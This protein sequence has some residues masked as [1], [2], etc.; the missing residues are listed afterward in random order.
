MEYEESQWSRTGVAQRFAVRVSGPA[1]RALSPPELSEE[2]VALSW[3]VVEVE[4]HEALDEL[5]SYRIRLKRARGFDPEWKRW[6]RDSRAA[7]GQALTL[8]VALPGGGREHRAGP[9]TWTWVQGW[10]PISG[11]LTHITH[12]GWDER[13][14]EYEMELGPWLYAA[15]LRG[16]RRI[17]QDLDVR[18]ILEQLLGAY[19]GPVQW[20]LADRYPRR[21]FQVQYRE[22]DLE[23]FERMVQEWGI[24]YHFE[25]EVG[26]CT[27]VLGDNLSAFPPPKAPAYERLWCLEGSLGGGHEPRWARHPECIEALHWCE[28]LVPGRWEGSD[29]DYQHPW[30]VS[31]VSER[32]ELPTAHG[33]LGGSHW[34]GNAGVDVAQPAAGHLPPRRGQDNLREQAQWL[35]RRRLQALRAPYQRARGHGALRGVQPGTRLYAQGHWNT[36][37]NDYFVVLGTRLR[38]AAPEGWSAPPW[39]WCEAREDGAWELRCE[40]ELQPTRTPVRPELRRPKPPVESFQTA[41]VMGHTPMPGRHPGEPCVDALGR[42]RVRLDWDERQPHDERASCWVRMTAPAAADQAGEIWVPRAGQEVVVSFLEGDCDTPVCVGALYSEAN[43]PPWTLPENAAL[44]GIRSREL[45]LRHGGNREAGRSNQLVF[46][47]TP[48]QLQAQLASEQARSQLSLGVLTELLGVRGRGH[49][50]HGRSRGEGFELRSD[51]EGVVRAGRGLLLSTHARRRAV[52]AMLGLHEPLRQLRRAQ[53]QWMRALQ[54]EYQFD[55]NDPHWKVDREE[56]RRRVHAHVHKLQRWKEQARQ[57]LRERNES[58]RIGAR[59]QAQREK[60]QGG[61]QPAAPKQASGNAPGNA[62]AN[63]QTNAQTNAQAHEPAPDAKA[64][65]AGDTADGPVSPLLVSSAG[66]LLGVS[67]QG[68][69]LVAQGSLAVGAGG[70]VQLSAARKLLLSAKRG[71]QVLAR[72]AGLFL[73]ARAGLV[74]LEAHQGEMRLE[75]RDIV[76]ESAEDW[77]EIVGEKELVAEFGNTRLRLSEEGI[78]IEAPAEFIAEAA[79]HGFDGP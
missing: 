20:R 5:F 73:V 72:R 8:H 26:C 53:A 75:G 32:D 46:D 29:Y 44:S 9:H 51:G 15:T 56:F 1:L 14:D 54:E 37:C 24:H 6:Q 18:E 49:P 41:L 65:E 66:S 11:V 77:V 69:R 76:L 21:D 68:I 27:L 4:G 78:E 71:L 64:A 7:L 36:P 74:K 42:I 10:R 28:K 12:M 25:H 79:R 40:F 34:R 35:A 50:V 39:E 62:Q 70:D 60:Q 22:T 19:P 57:E 23:F 38:M 3:R 63:A 31:T 48:G 47:D 45:S 2:E 55:L 16:D 33:D 61:A 30:W 13:D 17:Y 43:P 67:D 58:Q 52:G 59:A